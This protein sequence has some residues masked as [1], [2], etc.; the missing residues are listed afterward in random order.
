MVKDR[1]STEFWQQEIQRGL[2]YRKDY[3]NC[4]QWATNRK[5]FRHQ[6]PQL[7]GLPSNIQQYNF[8]LIRSQAMTL[9]PSVLI[10]NPYISVTPT[11]KVGVGPIE[12][13]IRQIRAKILEATDNW[14][15]KEV[16]LHKEVRKV[17][18]DHFLCGVGIVKM[19]YDSQYGFIP[20]NMDEMLR[21]TDDQLD[22]KNKE[23]VEHNLNVHAG[24]PWSL[25]TLPDFIVVPFG[26]RNINELEWI[27]HVVYR[28]LVDIKMDKRYKNTAGLNG[29]HVDTSFRESNLKF[30]NEMLGQPNEWIELVEIRDIK[31]GQVKTM[32]FG[33]KQWLREPE[34]DVLQVDGIPFV[35]Y[36]VV[37]DPEYF[38]EVADA[39]T[40]EDQQLEMIESRTQ[41]A[42]HR[43]I[44]LLKFIYDVNKLKGDEL[45][46]FLR[47]DIGV[48]VGMEGGVSDAITILQPHIPGDLI[49]WNE[50][51]LGDA[52]MQLGYGRNQMADV[53]GSSRRSAAEANIVDRG[54]SLRSMDRMN[55]T[56]DLYST[57]LRKVNQLFFR[58][59][60]AEKSAQVVGF[61]GM[62]YWI[63]LNVSEIKGEYNEN[64][65]VESFQ[66]PSKGTR[67]Q[68]LLQ[69]M[70]IFAR[71]PGA[72]MDFLMQ[73]FAREYTW[74]DTMSIFPNAQETLTQPMQ[75][76]DFMKQQM[77]LIQNPAQMMSRRKGAV[78]KMM[79]PMGQ[80]G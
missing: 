13:Y 52:R 21:E 45:N 42:M 70:Q 65:D 14:Y 77:T 9:V 25:R 56:A 31:R 24:M 54:N 41:A 11:Y 75:Q 17:I 6:F 22:K 38:W 43:R 49:A 1:N 18:L 48:G 5:Y 35:D 36:R 16:A 7:A 33:Y 8:N 3:G 27:G 73:A 50:A 71:S 23:K 79:L 66:P 12:S 15:V 76:E 74:M 67:R 53:E 2:I 63:N 57:I 30:Y 68:D 61:D 80:G 46:K 60:T 72:N 34:E 58:F 4:S 37:E 62:R 59:W 39:S 26:G 69:M 64:V 28:R 47:G 29:T 20:D 51:I 78:E 19:G 44:A 10:R 55:A 40:I 32:A